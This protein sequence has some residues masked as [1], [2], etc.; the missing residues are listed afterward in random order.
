MHRVCGRGAHLGRAP[1]CQGGGGELEPRRPL[2]HEA[3]IVCA[4]MHDDGFF[5]QKLHQMLTTR[6][7]GPYNETIVGKQVLTACG[8]PARRRWGR[9][10]ARKK[11][12][13]TRGPGKYNRY[14]LRH[15]RAAVGILA[16]LMVDYIQLLVP[17]LYLPGHQRRFN[18]TGGGEGRRCSRKRCVPHICLP[19]SADRVHGGGALLWRTAFGT[20]I[21]VQAT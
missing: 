18:P 5:Q 17:Q 21:R 11:G 2:Q 12:G 8:R 3:I 13:K 20:S 1:P 4:E 9:L 6:C 19:M 7:S 10:C 14:Y 15:A 16:L